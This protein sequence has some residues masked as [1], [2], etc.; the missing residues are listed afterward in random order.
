MMVALRVIAAVYLAG[1]VVT[2]AMAFKVVWNDKGPGAPSWPLKILFVAGMAAAWFVVFVRVIVE[3]Y[4]DI[5][6]GG[7]RN[8]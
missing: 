1:F 5:R 6:S 3:D 8:A 7:G 2:G 4:R